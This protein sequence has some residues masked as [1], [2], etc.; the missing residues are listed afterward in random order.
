VQPIGPARDFL[1]DLVNANHDEEEIEIQQPELP[2]PPEEVHLMALAD[3]HHEIPHLPVFLAM[4]DE[5]IGLDQ[6]IDDEKFELPNIIEVEHPFVQELVSEEQ[7][8][9]QQMVPK[10]HNEEQQLVP[11]EF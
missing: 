4:I 9:V 1:N 10:E 5:E 8:M 11:K 3:E 7:I 2:Q 6:L